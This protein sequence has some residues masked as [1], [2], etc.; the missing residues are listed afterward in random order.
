[1]KAL[2][3]F[4]WNVDTSDNTDNTGC[5]GTVAT[6]S[7]TTF[8]KSKISCS[9]ST[10]FSAR[11]SWVGLK[12]GFGTVR[13]GRSGSPYKQTGVALDPFVT[14]SLEARNNFGMSGNADGHGV[15]LAH[16]SFVSEG[17]FYTS[18]EFVGLSVDAYVGLDGTGSNLAVGNSNQGGQTNGDLSV[19]LRWKGGPINAFVAYNKAANVVT[20]AALAP[21]PTA[22]KVGGQ[23]KLAKM[24]TISF[25]YEKTDRDN[26]PTN[27]T[28]EGEYIFLGYQFKLG[29]T[30]LVAQGGLFENGGGDVTGVL[31][32]DA[33]YY[34]LGAIYNFSK[35]F[36]VFGGYRATELENE[37]VTP[38][39]IQTVRDDNVITVGMRK[40]F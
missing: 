33:T 24:H 20:T 40:D 37:D 3:K 23:V 26:R 10:P 19:A 25:Q 12:G 39:N 34:A 16:N 22:M 4:E 21:E 31:N 5:S 2:A 18:P 7:G 15:L 17:L 28:D 1:M 8:T 9:T 29:N 11:D 36:R 30:T 13:L 38:G 27:D 6:I 14:T 35:T 32:Q